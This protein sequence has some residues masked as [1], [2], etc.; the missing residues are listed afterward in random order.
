MIEIYDL[1]KYE[2]DY[3]RY[4]S[5]RTGAKFPII[6]DGERWMIKFP[7]SASGFSAKSTKNIP[8]Y[9][10][11][12]LSEYLGSH[13][14]ESLNIPVHETILGFRENKIVVGCKDFDPM[15]TLVPYH[16]IRNSITE[17]EATLSSSSSSSGE[18]LSDALKVINTAPV[19]KNNPVIKERF[20]DMF[21]VDAFIRNNDR[22]NGN[23]GFFINGDGTATPAPVFDNG[24][25]F[26]NKRTSIVAESHLKN[27]SSMIQDAYGTGVS[28]FLD[29]D[30]SHIHPFDFIE[31]GVS[32]DCTKAL[33]RFIAHCNLENIM[34]IFDEIP[35]SAF[36]KEVLSPST[37]QHYKTML[38]LSYKD[39]LLPAYKKL[40]S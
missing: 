38:Q 32:S 6:I 3:S 29:N 5:G 15:K 16:D 33:K 12:P 23:W 37:K 4:Y 30:G 7:E 36:D 19:L 24:N 2:R 26:F 18:P 21:V 34:A 28:F 25:S 8:S 11:S 17:N 39:R 20:W 35:E 40:C 10:S 13:I 27:S 22:N 31:S 9:T 1:G 14:Y